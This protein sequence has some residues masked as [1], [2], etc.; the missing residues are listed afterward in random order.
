MLTQLTFS[1]SLRRSDGIRFSLYFAR[2]RRRR[3]TLP[4]VAAMRG[5]SGGNVVKIGG[6]ATCSSRRR[7][8][9]TRVVAGHG[10][11]GRQA[12]RSVGVEFRVGGAVFNRPN[13]RLGQFAF[14]EFRSFVEKL[15]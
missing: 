15:S 6:G 11:G 9:V 13:R 10:A 2:F 12:V 8:L 4:G 14:V 1:P 5:G 7:P 3:R